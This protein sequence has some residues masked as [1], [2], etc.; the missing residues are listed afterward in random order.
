MRG[1]NMPVRELPGLVQV[2]AEMGDNLGFVE[3]R[4]EIQIGGSV[5]DGIGVQNH[6]PIHLARIQIG[7]KLLEAAI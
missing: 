4:G 3:G 7:D 2:Q 6:Q 5:V 1:G